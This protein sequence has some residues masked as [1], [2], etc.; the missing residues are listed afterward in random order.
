M[1]RFDCDHERKAADVVEFPIRRPSRRAV[2]GLSAQRLSD[3]EHEFA[4]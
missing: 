4:F 2:N 1:E 3:L